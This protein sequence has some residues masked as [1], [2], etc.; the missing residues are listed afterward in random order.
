MLKAWD[1]DP[2]GPP[3]TMG[4]K[5]KA[6]VLNCLCTKHPDTGHATLGMTKKTEEVDEVVN[7][8][9]AYAAS[10]AGGDVNNAGSDGSDGSDHSDVDETTTTLLDEHEEPTAA[11]TEPMKPE[12]IAKKLK[13]I[14]QDKENVKNAMSTIAHKLEKE[15]SSFNK[16]RSFKKEKVKLTIMK[17]KANAKALKMFEEISKMTIKRRLALVRSCL[18]TMMGSGQNVLYW[19]LRK[20]FAKTPIE[21][22]CSVLKAYQ[23]PTLQM[24]GW[25]EKFVMKKT[26]PTNGEDQR[27]VG[28]YKCIFLFHALYWLVANVSVIFVFFSISKVTCGTTTKRW[29]CCDR[30]W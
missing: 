14:E 4:A 23:F 27:P 22:Q 26:T 16:E 12:D 18:K 3:D 6:V 1:A 28:K 8:S 17:R 15:D 19:E 11:I 13:K 21:A 7:A 29:Q 20:L 2:N 10:V 25:K 24:H 30:I 5:I 9:T